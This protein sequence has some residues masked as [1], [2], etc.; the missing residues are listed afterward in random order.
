MRLLRSEPA[1]SKASPSMQW[2]PQLGPHGPG[3]QI[4]IQT[5]SHIQ[6]PL[7]S[8]C[9]PTHAAPYPFALFHLPS[10]LPLAQNSPCASWCRS[11]LLGACFGIAGPVWLPASVLHQKHWCKR[12]Q[13][14][15]ADASGLCRPRGGGCSEFK[16]I[17]YLLN[18][19]RPKNLKRINH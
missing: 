7:L 8:L 16:I 17:F 9:C 1:V 6:I 13:K 5:N 11:S 18:R 10:H 14:C 3:T 15:S 12:L 19:S 2:Q 4:W